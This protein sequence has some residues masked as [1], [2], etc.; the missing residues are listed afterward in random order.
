MIQGFLLILPIMCCIWTGWLLKR[1]GI[2]NDEG[3]EQ[4]GRVVFYLAAPCIVFR[5][6]YA[7]KPA[8]FADVNFSIVLNAGYVVIILISCVMQLFR[9]CSIQRK[10]ASVMM[11]IRS[12]NMFMGMPAVIIMWGEQILPAFGRYMALAEVGFEFLSALS[13]LVVLNG[14]LN[15]R[16]LRRVGVSLL[17]NPVIISIILALTFGMGLHVKLPRWLSLSIDILGDLGT[18]LALLTLGMKLKPAELF[19]DLSVVWPEVL[20]RLFLAPLIL[21]AGFRLLP[22]EPAMEKIGILTMGMP[23]AMNTYPMAAAMGMDDDYTAQSIMV[24][25]VLSVFTLPV[26][27]RFLL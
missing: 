3:G 22:V 18:G 15:S 19:H 6:V 9:R 5:F 8:D 11:S 16:S 17:H 1:I 13:G 23:V 27:I 14:G 24:S 10:A 2:F 12:N 25:T 4:M 26:I 7:L 20:M 21:W